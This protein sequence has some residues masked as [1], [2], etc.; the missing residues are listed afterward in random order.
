MASSLPIEV[1][2]AVEGNL[3]EV[4]FR[5]VVEFCGGQPGKVLGF[6]GRG[7]LLKNISGYNA[8]ARHGPWFVLVDLDQ[9]PECAPTLVVDSLPEPAA[10]MCFRVAVHEV[11]AWLLG[12]SAG[13]AKWSGVRKSLIP[14]DVETVAHPKEKLVEIVR[15]SRRSNIREAIVPRQGSGR[16]EGPAYSSTLS[17]FVAERWDIEAAAQAAPSLERAIRCLKAKIASPPTPGQ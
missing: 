17:E 11:E 13:F 15:Q 10:G 12:D 2:A 4:V 8:G 5:C 7:Y 3:D 9:D 16:T 6:K 1:R 14:S